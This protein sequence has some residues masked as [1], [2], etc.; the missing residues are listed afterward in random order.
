MK[1]IAKLKNWYETYERKISVASLAS[2]FFVDALT[3]QRIDAL[4]ENLW[5]AGNL[6]L[7]GLCIVLLNRGKSEGAKHF[8]L[9]NL[10]QFSFGTLLGSVFIFYFR[11]ATLSATWPFLLMLL[12]A[13]LGNEL[14][15]K[16]YEKLAFQ[17]SFFYFSLF[18][19]TIFLVPL[20]L[21]NIGAEIFVLSG[22]VSLVLLWLFLEVLRRFAREK[23]I[24]GR[25]HIWV[26]V[27]LIF[28][29]INGLYFTNLI[30]PI[31]LSM[32]EAGIYHSIEKSTKGNYIVEAEVRGPEKYFTLREPIHWKQGEALYAYTAIFSPGS[33][34]TDIAHEWQYKDEAGEWVTATRI[35]LYLS[36]GRQGGF[37]TYSNK[38]NFTPGDWRVDVKT[39][40]GQLIGR[41]SFEIIVVDQIPELVPEVKK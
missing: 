2:G 19:F 38:Y 22:V 34:N 29:C 27:S 31:P 8:W 21:K 5:I 40:R 7:A 36:G 39:L 10:L 13:M 14:Y 3:M 35:P 9:S 41:I 20:F 24:E 4:R 12:V 33:L 26:L 30:P 32:K 18:S 28:I 37:R 15:Q 17:L 23:F 1:K 16:R 11:S 25:T 6:L